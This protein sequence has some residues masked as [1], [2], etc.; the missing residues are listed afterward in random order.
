V[1]KRGLANGCLQSSTGGYEVALQNDPG[2]GFKWVITV[3]RAGIV[4]AVTS[5]ERLPRPAAS[6]APR[7]QPS[8]YVDPSRTPNDCAIIA[9]QAY[10]KLKPSTY[11]CEVIGV[12]FQI[13]GT[14]WPQDHAMVFFKYQA[15]GT[16]W[17][18]DERGSKE[19]PTTSTTL[20]DLK[21][22]MESQLADGVMVTL[23]DVTH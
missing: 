5:P 22:A 7:Q 1:F 20:A 21:L 8:Y 12:H 17:V 6:L 16:V 3:G 2:E 14:D 9:A 10:A 19:I 23:R 13:N 18:Y 15:D 11:W 4:A